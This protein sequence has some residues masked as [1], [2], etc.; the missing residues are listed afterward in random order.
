MIYFGDLLNL[1]HCQSFWSTIVRRFLPSALL[2]PHTKC[3]PDKQ[4]RGSQGE[5][6]PAGHVN[7]NP[8]L[9]AT[10]VLGSCTH[11][12]KKWDSRKMVAKVIMPQVNTCSSQ[13]LCCDIENNGVE[14]T[15]SSYVPSC[16]STRL[17]QSELKFLGYIFSAKGVQVD[18]AKVSI[19]KDWPVPDTKH[20]TRKP[21]SCKLLSQVHGLRKVGWQ[22][23]LGTS[24]YHLLKALSELHG[25]GFYK[26]CKI[27]QA[28]S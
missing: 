7:A 22:S 23:F 5:G 9:S 26:D 28:S 16:P 12:P 27:P 24:L 25:Q 20:E 2:H 4:G 13:T 6:L 3:I 18:P 17:V 14:F 11:R 8:Y 15:G 1:Q 10:Q 21:W 19:V